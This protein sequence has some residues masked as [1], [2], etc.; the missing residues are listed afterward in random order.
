M[1]PALWERFAVQLFRDGVSQLRAQKCQQSL[2]LGSPLGLLVDFDPFAQLT[3]AREYTQRMGED[4]ELRFSRGAKHVK[5]FQRY[6][7]QTD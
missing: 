4:G 6:S 3:R 5:F 7:H 1:R 2:I